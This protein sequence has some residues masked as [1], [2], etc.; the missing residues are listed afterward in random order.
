MLKGDVNGLHNSISW[1][2]KYNSTWSELESLI[3]NITNKNTEHIEIFEQ[4]NEKIIRLKHLT[5]FTVCN[6]IKD[7][8]HIIYIGLK[9]D[10]SMYLVDPHR[11]TNHRI[12]TLS[13]KGDNIAIP[14]FVDTS[15]STSIIIDVKTT[16]FKKR[17]DRGKCNN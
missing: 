15:H 8:R 6:E 9:K 14:E 3:L 7:F 17:T 13:M 12:N 1:K 5:P 4:T 16:V 10:V 2:G 11:F